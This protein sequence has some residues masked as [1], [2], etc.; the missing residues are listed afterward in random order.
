MRHLLPFVVRE[1]P[2]PLRNMGS[3]PDPSNELSNPSK[4]IVRLCQPNVRRHPSSSDPSSRK[5]DVI[6]MTWAQF[7]LR[8]RCAKATGAWAPSALSLPTVGKKR[9]SWLGRARKSASERD[10]LVGGQLSA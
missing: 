3:S 1:Q 6:E 2:L 4:A 8:F 9:R 7:K 10:L 5:L